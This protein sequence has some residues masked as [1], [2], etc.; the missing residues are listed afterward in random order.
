VKEGRGLRA[1]SGRR[2][3][4]I[5][6]PAG[7]IPADADGAG[8]SEGGASQEAGGTGGRRESLEALYARHAPDAVRLATLLTRDSA[9]AQDLVHDAFARLGG[10]L[11]HLRRPEAFDAY[12]RRTVVNMARMHF[13]RRLVERAWL[14]RQSTVEHFLADESPGVEDRDA[15]RRAL[16]RL[17]ERQRA[18]LVLRFYEDLTHEQIATTLRCRPG[19]AASLVSRGLA[20]LRQDLEAPTWKE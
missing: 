20:R 15:L 16:H 19:T 6:S 4:P 5:A 3:D 9:L 13:R 18:A 8:R 17:P 12:L 11:V 14:A 7:S 1:S 2:L 10:R